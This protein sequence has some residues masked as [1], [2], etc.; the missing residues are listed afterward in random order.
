MDGWPIIQQIHKL[1][2]KDILKEQEFH[3][4]LFLRPTLHWIM[5]LL[6]VLSYHLPL[7]ILFRLL[8]LLLI[9]LLVLQLTRLLRPEESTLLASLQRLLK[10]S[11]YRN[12]FC[13]IR[14]D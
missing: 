13:Q 8:V 2:Y 1:L 9:H 3:L 5:K 4:F 6:E 14:L 12:I 11:I 7:W 10:V